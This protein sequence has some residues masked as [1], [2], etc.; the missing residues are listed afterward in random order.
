[1]DA[2]GPP[3]F[4]YFCTLVLLW[5]LNLRDEYL[6]AAGPD[7]P[8]K[9]MYEGLGAVAMTASGVLN[10]LILPIILITLAAGWQIAKRKAQAMSLL[11]ASKGLDP[12]EIQA[13]TGRKPPAAR[14]KVDPGAS[15]GWRR[16]KA[17]SFEMD[18]WRLASEVRQL[19]RQGRQGSLLVS[20]ACTSAHVT[21]Y[22]T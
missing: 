13:R 15:V 11:E 10:S 8:P 17:E 12:A 9:P 5:N 19:A 3:C 22:W 20:A 6:Q 16:H 4:L 2:Y 18:S 21:E 1:M 7:E 14:A